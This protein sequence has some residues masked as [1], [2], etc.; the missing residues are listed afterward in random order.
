LLTFAFGLVHGLAFAEAL[1]ELHLSDWPLARALLGFNL[2]VESGQ[3]LLVLLLVP[4]LAWLARRAN[5]PRVAQVLSAGI[6]GM[7]LLWL[8]QRLLLA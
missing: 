3:A 8:T 1:T 7:G 6:A 2:G 4:T 5:G